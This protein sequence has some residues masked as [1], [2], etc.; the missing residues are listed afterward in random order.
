ME[1]LILKQQCLKTAIQQDFLEEQFGTRGCTLHSHRKKKKTKRIH[2]KN[3]P[4]PLPP[5]SPN[6]KRK[7]LSNDHVRGW[8]FFFNQYSSSCLH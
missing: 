1:H 8:P 4:H 7:A 2:A 5:F 3:N 6:P